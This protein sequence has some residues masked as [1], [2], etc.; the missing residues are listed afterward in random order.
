MLADLEDGDNAGMVKVGGG[1]GLQVESLN[2][3]LAREATGEDHFEGDGPVEFDLPG[4][5]YDAHSATR[6]LALKF[7]IAEIAD[8][9]T[10]RQV[11]HG[12]G[13]IGGL[14]G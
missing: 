13:A 14:G 11:A 2:L 4:L 6:D 3:G 8:D 10:A 9:G 7:V 5:V 1:L 12:P